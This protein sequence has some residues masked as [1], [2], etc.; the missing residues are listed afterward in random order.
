MY[1]CMYCWISMCFTNRITRIRYSRYQNLRSIKV[2][3]SLFFSYEFAQRFKLVYFRSYEHNSYLQ[4]D[5]KILR[6]RKHQRTISKELLWTFFFVMQR[7][8]SAV[9]FL[10]QNIILYSS[11]SI[12]NVQKFYN[13]TRRS[14]QSV[15][16]D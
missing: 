1:Y 16:C 12:E 7:R 14:V 15:R 4:G 6:C 10:Y 13:C 5:F 8:H 3:F 2:C 11:N 9:S